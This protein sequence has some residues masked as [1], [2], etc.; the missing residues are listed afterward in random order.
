VCEENMRG[1]RFNLLDVTVRLSFPRPR[2]LTYKLFGSCTPMPSIVEED[3][4]FPPLQEPV[5]QGK[6]P[7]HSTACSP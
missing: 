2:P 5:F 7:Q 3:S 1:V 4:S 6:N